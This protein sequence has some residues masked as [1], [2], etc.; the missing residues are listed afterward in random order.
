MRSF[1]TLHQGQ[2]TTQAYYERFNAAIDV[3]KE[4]GGNIGTSHTAT[5]YILE[6]NGT[7]PSSATSQQ[8]AAA[9]ITGAEMYK[10]IAFTLGADRKRFGKLIEDLSNNYLLGNNNYPK[11]MISAYNLLQ[12]WRR[13]PKN[14]IQ[15][16]GPTNDGTV[17]VTT[18][19]E[20]NRSRDKIVCYKCGKTGH[21]AN[22]N[23]CDDAEDA[24][25]HLQQ[26]AKQPDEDEEDNDKKDKQQEEETSED[27]EERETSLLMAAL[28]SG[29]L[30]NTTDTAFIFSQGSMQH[31]SYKNGNVFHIHN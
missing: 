15:I 5:N 25:T 30:D 28:E 27:E 18:N 10:A 2:D 26:A 1:Y 4:M 17:F 24:Q 23:K 7:V 14:L 21:Y 13:D 6:A 31:N 3:V 22:E 8:R 9:S 29:E 12:N 11:T 16:N 19:G 20:R